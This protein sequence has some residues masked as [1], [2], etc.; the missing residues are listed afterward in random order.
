MNFFLWAMWHN[1][2]KGVSADGLVSQ[3]QQKKKRQNNLWAW[4]LRILLMFAMF[5]LWGR[6]YCRFV[7]LFEQ[8]EYSK[9]M[10]KFW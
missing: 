10:V 7:F 8:S 5:A 1:F 9:E 6:N 3:Q 2:G 4:M